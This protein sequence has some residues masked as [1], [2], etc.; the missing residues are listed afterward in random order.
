MNELVE[1]LKCVNASGISDPRNFTNDN[2]GMI[3]KK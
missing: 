2:F 3:E 1:F